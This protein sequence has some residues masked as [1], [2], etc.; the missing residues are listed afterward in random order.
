M[1]ADQVENLWDALAPLRQAEP[2]QSGV[3]VEQR[4]AG[5][6]IVEAEIFGQ[7][8]NASTRFGLACR[9]AKQARLAV[10]GADQSEEDFDGGR[11]TRAVGS[12]KAEDFTRLDGE[13]QP[14]KRNLPAVLLA[15]SDRFN[16]RRQ[17]RTARVSAMRLSSVA[18]SDPARPYM[19]PPSYQMAALPTP[20]LSFSN[21]PWCPLKLVDCQLT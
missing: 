20:E 21:S 9:V 13:V 5:Q 17:L 2:G 7:V 1:Q 14:V 15:K 19:C 10:R 4:G 18:L 11:L 16:G 12:Q 8:A 3:E 6:P